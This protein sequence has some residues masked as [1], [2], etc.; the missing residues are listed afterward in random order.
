MM[1]T[2]GSMLI[3][4]RILEEAKYVP[5]DV[6]AYRRV[7]RL[8]GAELGGD[9]EDSAGGHGAAADGRAAAAA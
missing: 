3:G 5:R 7:K 4:R 8:L 6:H 2:V 1:G 9:T